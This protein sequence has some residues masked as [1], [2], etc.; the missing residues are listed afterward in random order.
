[1]WRGR[2]TRPVYD[3]VRHLW[4]HGH[5]IPG[6]VAREDIPRIPKPHDIATNAEARALYKVKSREVYLANLASQ[7]RRMAVA[8]TL[9]IAGRMGDGPIWFPM[10][11][12]FRGRMYCDPQF[13]TP[14][15]SDLAKGLV[16]FN[17]GVPL[18]ERGLHWLKVHAA[19]CFGVDKVSVEERVA[20]VDASSSKIRSVAAEPL[21]EKWWH[22]ADSPVQ[23]LAACV[24][25]A[26][27]WSTGQAQNFVSYLPIMVDGSCNGIQHLSALS[28]DAQAGAFV[29]LLPAESPSDIYGRV[30]QETVSCLTFLSTS[31]SA[32]SSSRSGS[33]S[34]PWPV[35]SS[36][37]ASSSPSP[38]ASATEPYSGGCSS[39]SSEPLPFP[40]SGSSSLTAS[41]HPSPAASLSSSAGSTGYSVAQLAR[42]WIEYG[43]DRGICKRPTMIL[44]YGGT[45]QAVSQYIDEAITERFMAG[46][47]HPFGSQRRQAVAFLAGVVWE[48][49]GRVVEGPRDIM[50]WTRTVASVLSKAQ[51]PIR[52][53][54]PSG[55]LVIQ[56]YTETS[57]RKVKTKLGD[58]VL[59]LRLS[60]PTDKI[61]PR[62]QARALAPN[63]IHSLDAAA[64]H[65]TIVSMVG[66]GVVD[67]AAVHDS[68][69]CHAAHMDIMATTLR[70]EFVKMY[71]EDVLKRFVD[72][73]SKPVG[74]D[75]VPAPPPKGS[76][77]I[78]QVLLSRYF[79]A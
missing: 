52:W 23:F 8:S 33:S 34:S 7:G 9:N 3:V 18:G 68:Y 10:S 2:G 29:N 58:S 1:M 39:S 56:A 55:F 15:G 70:E 44:P 66:Q 46:K 42:L 13:Y 19:N 47:P 57:S 62:G 45:L 37:T 61:D 69:G 79:F 27:A 64:L 35:P 77:D 28:R 54:T 53:T 26:A 36:S 25:L 38:T 63:W 16:R 22:E 48:A 50:R 78:E 60:Q 41:S 5:D 24:E 49:M 32:S 21:V 74:V 72:D 6:A 31:E 4:N 43:V 76:L 75:K 20:W 17:R 67:I 40:L 71:R 65:L 12:D 14:Q 73:T 59:Q 11:L 30:A 51:Q